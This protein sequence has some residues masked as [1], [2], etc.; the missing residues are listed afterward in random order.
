MDRQLLNQRPTRMNSTIFADRTQGEFSKLDRFKQF[1]AGEAAKQQFRIRRAFD[2]SCNHLKGRKYSKAV[3]GF[4]QLIRQ[5]HPDKRAR[6]AVFSNLGIAY[7]RMGKF[8]T[9]LA[10]YRCANKLFP[11]QETAKKGLELA[12][13][14]RR[15]AD[16]FRFQT[17]L[18]KVALAL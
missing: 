8:A 16:V 12:Q 13:K 14:L 7:E 5:V 15:P 9:A 18:C 2:R 10:A 3:L 17:I 4:R 11:T 1:M 6:A